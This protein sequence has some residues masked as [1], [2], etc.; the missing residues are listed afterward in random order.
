MIK[1]E[2]WR[3]VFR[4]LSV[5]LL[6]GVI[7]NSVTFQAYGVA[8]RSLETLRREHPAMHEPLPHNTVPCGA[9]GNLARRLGGAENN[10]LERAA[11]GDSAH[12]CTRR[13]GDG[14]AAASRHLPPM[15]C[16]RLHAK[17]G[18][19]QQAATSQ[20][21][22]RMLLQHMPRLEDKQ[23]ATSGQLPPTRSEPRVCRGSE[24]VEM[25]SSTASQ[26][27][28]ATPAWQA[29]QEP[30]PLAVIAAAGA[31]A[32]GAQCLVTVPQELLK[33]RMQVQTGRDHEA[34]YVPTHRMAAQILRTSGPAGFFKGFGI[35]LLR[36]V[37]SYALYFWVYEVRS[38][39]CPVWIPSLLMLSFVRSV[40]IFDSCDS[41]QIWHLQESRDSA[42]AGRAKLRISLLGV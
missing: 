19:D 5:P 16:V 40:C 15:H 30:H 10:A 11:A 18:Q 13:Q 35:T 3:S 41:K 28:A 38:V 29:V 17:A 24:A 34:A 7:Q 2:G 9:S 23:A 31:V 26:S 33:I 4:G 1:A 22:P 20:K 8:L 32:G 12:D 21:Q 36:D 39:D 25:A 14:Q 6:T 42:A 27:I 37:P